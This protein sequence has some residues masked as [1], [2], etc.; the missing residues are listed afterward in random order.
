MDFKTQILEYK[1]Q[2]IDFRR[3]LH[4]HPEASM[5]EV[6]TTAKIIE[7]LEAAGIEYQRVD[8]TGVVATIKGGKPGKTV[9]LRADIDALAIQENTGLDF[10]SVNDG[11]M[12]ACG[13]DAHATGLLGGA[14]LLNNCKQEL[15]GTVK[16]I[17]QPA[18]EV[19][20]GASAVIS[21]GF[22]DDVDMVFGMHN[23]PSLP[24]GSIAGSVG[25]VFAAATWFK[26]KVKGKACHGALPHTG[27]DATVA[28]AAIVMNLQ[29]LVSRN[30]S[31][32]D[33]AVVTVGMLQS[34][35]RF[36]IVSGEA[37]MEGTVRCLSSDVYNRV[38]DLME[39]VC[40]STA[41]ALGAEV[42]IIHDPITK[43]LEN[44]PAVTE[45]ALRS[46]QKIVSDPSLVLPQDLQMGG[47]DFAEYCDKAPAA[48][49]LYGTGGDYPWHSD[50]YVINE[51]AML[52]A[53][54]MYAQV[55]YD[56]LGQ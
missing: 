6:R 15:C 53:A 26:I 43:V 19:C 35:S 48:F 49:F 50:K 11:L 20:K 5:E 30:F 13:H 27:V 17:F 37:Y 14:L 36:N 7:A 10:C 39:R 46:A 42:E 56:A 32:M 1:Q 25:P 47:E 2:L 41:E 28:A 40:K 22:V 4:R 54:A 55:A 51:D 9:A 44:D 38:F 23:M 8:P 18:E 45:L 12:H 21:Q 29:T 24:S 34:G 31:P 16:L 33:S 52:T 3:D